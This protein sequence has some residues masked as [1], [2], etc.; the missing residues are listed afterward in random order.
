MLGYICSVQIN[1]K[2]KEPVKLNLNINPGGTATRNCSISQDG[3]RLYFSGWGGYG[4]WDLWYSDWND[5]TNDWSPAINMGP[6]INSNFLEKLYLRSEQR[7]YL[8][9]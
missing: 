7:Y 5:T 3:K 1:G 4:G 9:N 2:W 6:E 8:R